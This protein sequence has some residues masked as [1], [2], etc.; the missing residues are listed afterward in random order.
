MKR[1]QKRLEADKYT[2]LCEK[3]RRKTNGREKNVYAENCR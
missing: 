3:M 1:L 2:A